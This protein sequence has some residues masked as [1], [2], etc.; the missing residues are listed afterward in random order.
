MNYS[1]GLLFDLAPAPSGAE[2]AG[3]R[4]T[5]PMEWMINAALVGQ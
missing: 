5:F 1:V 3:S 2:G 4:M